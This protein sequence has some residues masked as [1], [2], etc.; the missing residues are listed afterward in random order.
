MSA[1]CGRILS[2]KVRCHARRQLQ[3]WL[4]AFATYAFDSKT[5]TASTS[6][7]GHASDAA[8]AASEVRELSGGGELHR[9]PLQR[10]PGTL[11]MKPRNESSQ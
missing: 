9:V 7:D 1:V 8:A 2:S 5:A 4:L 10:L 6:E 11:E 3:A